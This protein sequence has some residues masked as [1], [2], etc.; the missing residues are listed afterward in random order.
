LILALGVCN[1]ALLI[2]ALGVCNSA[3]LILALGVC[4]S[5]NKRKTRVKLLLIK[6]VIFIRG[7][8]DCNYK[9]RALW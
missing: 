3:L 6:V 8:R 9:V 7:N 1:S 4:N 5:I 2:L